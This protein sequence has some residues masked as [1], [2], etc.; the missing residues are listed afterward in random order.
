LLRKRG[1]AGG[2]R[3]ERGRGRDDGDLDLIGRALAR[4]SRN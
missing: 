1:Q 2:E 4:K 3:G